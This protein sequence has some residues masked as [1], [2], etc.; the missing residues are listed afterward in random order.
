MKFGE[1]NDLRIVYFCE[2][3]HYNTKKDF[4]EWDLFSTKKLALES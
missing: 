3:A 1:K 4:W 2:D